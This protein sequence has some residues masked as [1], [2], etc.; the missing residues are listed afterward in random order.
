MALLAINIDYREE[1]IIMSP[2]AEQTDKKSAD[3]E[4]EKTVILQRCDKHGIVYMAN[5]GCPEC[6]K[7]NDS[8]GSDG[9]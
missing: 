6:E 8:A 4:L 5:E 1:E 2:D 7:E 9:S 3:T